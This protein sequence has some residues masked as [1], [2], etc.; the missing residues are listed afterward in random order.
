MPF[1]GIKIILHKRCGGH[2]ILLHRWTQGHPPGQKG[3]RCAASQRLCCAVCTSFRPSAAGSAS[4][5]STSCMVSC[6][7]SAA[8]VSGTGGSGSSHTKGGSSCTAT[9]VRVHSSVSSSAAGAPSGCDVQGAVQQLQIA[10][11][12]KT[13][14]PFPLRRRKG[15]IFPRLVRI[16]VPG[17]CLHAGIQ[18]RQRK[19][20]RFVQCVLQKQVELG[21]WVG[22]SGCGIPKSGRETCPPPMGNLLEKNAGALYYKQKGR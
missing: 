16:D 18:R 17:R 5:S 21:Q 20:A 6:S 13:G 12:Q 10:L 15:Q 4:M 3:I 2:S 7:A 22:G 8:G 9:V 14:I 11:G 1:C 19:A